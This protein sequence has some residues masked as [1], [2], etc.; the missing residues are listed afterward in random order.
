MTK[1]KRIVNAYNEYVKLI[2]VEAIQAPDLEAIEALRKVFTE[3][4]VDTSDLVFSQKQ[5]RRKS[6]KKEF[7]KM[8]GT[9]SPTTSHPC[10]NQ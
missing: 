1:T 10:R 8:A 9:C 5:M 7:P 6:S 2:D 4:V 3:A